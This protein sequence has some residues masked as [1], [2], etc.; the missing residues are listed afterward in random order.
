MTEPE[1]T[2]LKALIVEVLEDAKAQDIEVFD[3]RERNTF[4]D[5]MIVASGTST[6]QNTAMADRVIARI[7]ELGLPQPMGTE[8]QQ[9]GEWVLVDLNSVVLHLMLPQTRAFYNLEKLWNESV[10]ERAAKSV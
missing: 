3:L 7:K 2:A 10:R 9:H 4:A 6:R 5:F 1:P 8:G